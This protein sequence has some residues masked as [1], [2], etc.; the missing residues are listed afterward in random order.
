MHISRPISGFLLTLVWLVGFVHC[1]S[2]SAELHWHRSNESSAQRH[3]HHHEHS[4]QHHH[5]DQD[6]QASLWECCDWKVLYRPA[7]PDLGSAVF[8]ENIVFALSLAKALPIVSSKTFS[9]EHPPNHTASALEFIRTLRAP[10][11]PPALV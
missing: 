5:N 8:V 9:F 1:L 11:A 7:A 10:N 6:S 4:S 3:H 2:D